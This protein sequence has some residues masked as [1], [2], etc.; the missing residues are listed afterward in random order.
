[1]TQ[2]ERRADQVR[3]A[4]LQR[5]INAGLNV[6]ESWNRANAESSVAKPATSPPTAATSRK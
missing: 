6:A 3:A 1:M 5:E 2:A 4:L